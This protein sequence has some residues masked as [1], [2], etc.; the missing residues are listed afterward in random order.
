MKRIIT[1]AAATLVVLTGTGCGYTLRGSGSVL[2]ADVKNIYIPRVENGSTELGLADVVTDALRDEFDSYGT[3]SVVEKQGEA[4]AIL[5]VRIVD[6]KN[7]TGTVNAATNTALQMDTTMFLGGELRRTTGQILW[8]E[9]NLK[10]TKEYAANQ[11]VV[12]TTSPD[13][14]SGSISASD[15]ASLS[16]RD[17]SRGQEAQ[18]L[19]D[20]ASN[21]ARMIYDKSVAPDF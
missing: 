19:N 7:T 13:F 17:I 16:S 1:F 15:L 12:V 6:V 20:L 14:A 10:V 18:A 9:N 11:S 2:P 5:K 21:A 3:V 8:R 4:D